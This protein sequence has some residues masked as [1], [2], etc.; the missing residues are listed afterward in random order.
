[1]IDKIAHTFNVSDEDVTF[2]ASYDTVT[3]TSSVMFDF[4]NH[5]EPISF[6]LRQDHVSDS[7][8]CRITEIWVT[9]CSNPKMPP[10]QGCPLAG[11]Y[12]PSHN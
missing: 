5:Q 10:C 7:Y 4:S 6:W 3:N 8:E 11:D 9:H 2:S 12:T 1:M